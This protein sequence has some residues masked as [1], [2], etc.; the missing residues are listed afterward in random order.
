MT[1]VAV[2]VAFVIDGIH[3]PVG[4]VPFLDSPDPT[5]ITTMF[6]FISLA[7]LVVTTLEVD[8]VGYAAEH[9]PKPLPH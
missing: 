1:A 3:G 5:G 7:T 2:I 9:C 8:F 4:D 6:A